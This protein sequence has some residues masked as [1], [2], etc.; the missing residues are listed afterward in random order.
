MPP[1]S[2]PSLLFS[3]PHPSLTSP[4]PPFFPSLPIRPWPVLVP[5]DM[6]LSWDGLLGLGPS[7]ADLF[8]NI[9]ED[10]SLVER[11][12]RG[13]RSLLINTTHTWSTAN[14]KSWYLACYLLLRVMDGG[15]GR[16]LLY[17][18]LLIIIFVFL[19]FLFVWLI[20]VSVSNIQLRFGNGCLCSYSH[21]SSSGTQ[22]YFYDGSK[23]TRE[24]IGRVKMP[25]VCCIKILTF[26]RG[27]L[28]KKSPCRNFCKRY[29]VEADDPSAT[30]CYWIIIT[31]YINQLKKY[32]KIDIVS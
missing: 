16:F 8:T 24:K 15:G 32:S 13:R 3:L 4:L 27:I 29:L 14:N 22:A 10:S 7:D 2:P 12:G 19:S 28:H 9:E 31:C 30:I 11:S 21:I 18:Q 20:L 26:F 1:V 17:F 5:Y 23:E 6:T 25:L